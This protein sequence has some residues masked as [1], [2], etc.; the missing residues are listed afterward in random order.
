PPSPP[1]RE[2]F[3]PSPAAAPALLRKFVPRASILRPR[4][5]PVHSPPISWRNFLPSA[6]LLS[7]ESDCAPPRS[8]APISAKPLAQASPLSPHAILQPMPFP[9]AFRSSRHSFSHLHN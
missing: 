1:F 6:P 8:A 9:L 2:H 3:F 7:P 5:C 4:E